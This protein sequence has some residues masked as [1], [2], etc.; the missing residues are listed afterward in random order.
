MLLESTFGV[1]GQNFGQNQQAALDRTFNLTF[2]DDGS[3]FDFGPPIGSVQTLS[4]RYYT[5]REVL[6]TFRS[7]HSAKTGL[8]VMRT[9]VDGVNA[10]LGQW[11]T[12]KYF[13]LLPRDFTEANGELSLKQDVRRTVINKRFQD[14]IEA[15]YTRKPKDS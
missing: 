7:R 6:S 12:I 4:Q 13:T 8:E 11:E 5:V 9:T 1:R 14:Q 3:G 10:H 2:A 15:M